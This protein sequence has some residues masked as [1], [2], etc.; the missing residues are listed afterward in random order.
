[1]SHT[2]QKAT[3]AI[4]CRVSTRE[5]AEEGYSIGEQ[6]RLIREYCMK[7][8]YE[9]SAMARQVMGRVPL[10]KKCRIFSVVSAA[11]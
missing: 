2:E 5:Q 9:V 8:G 4:Y 3:A 11:L 1:M 6:E 7:Q 10:P